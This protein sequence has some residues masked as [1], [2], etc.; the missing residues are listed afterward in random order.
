MVKLEAQD[1]KK[2][3]KMYGIVEKQLRECLGGDVSIDHVGSTALPDMIGK[4]IID[5]LVG[6]KDKGHFEMLFKKIESLGYFPNTRKSEIYQ[7][8]ASSKGETKSGDVHIHLSIVG[9]ERYE[10]FLILRDYLLSN[11]KE[12][13]DYANYKKQ[14]VNNITDKRK[15]YKE[16]KGEYVTNLILRAKQNI[17]IKNN[18]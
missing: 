1:Y 4:N 6:S 3:K 17:S 5:I 18:D 2:N 9:T 14:I 15:E 13:Q 7:F 8:F 12:A 11:K 16:I 10:E